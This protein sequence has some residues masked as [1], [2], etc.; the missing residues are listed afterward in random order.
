MSW[1]TYI[2]EC[3]DSSYYVGI[4][5]NLQERVGEHNAGAGA[6]WTRFRR[7]LTLRFAEEFPDKSG[8]RKREIE[9]KGWRREKKERLFRSALNLVRPPP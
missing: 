1:F 2:V 4:T 5:S 7:P 9:I 8:A 6:S 3:S